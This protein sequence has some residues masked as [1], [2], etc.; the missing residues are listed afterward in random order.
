M[1]NGKRCRESLPLEPTPA[2]IK[3]AEQF[4]AAILESI[5]RGN[6]DYAVTF[7]NSKHAEELTN[8]KGQAIS[9]KVYFTRW[10]ND[11]KDEVKSS[12]FAGYKKITN[13]LIEEFGDYTLIELTPVLVKPW[14]RG[15]NVSKK[16]FSNILSV[17]RS[18]LNEA[19]KNEII[20]E[21]PFL[22][23][24]YEKKESVKTEKIDPFTIEEQREILS[25]C[26]EEE[27][28]QIQTF[29]WTGMRTG[30]LIALNWQDV[31]FH[32]GVIYVNKNIT[33]DS[34]GKFETPKTKAGNRAIKMLKPAR[35]ALMSQ[36]KITGHKDAVFL[37]PF[38]GERWDGSESIR[39]AWA[40]I[41]KRT[42]VRYRYPY[43]TRHTYA[44]MM[45]SAGE[46]I[47]WVAKQMG[48]S[49]WTMVARVYAKWIPD[50]NPT[51]G[52]KA[53]AIFG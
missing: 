18:A 1:Y 4:R 29:L 6:F 51:A 30:E 35:D 52:D 14:L 32:K 45:L 16:R 36:K 8:I 31:D 44:S 24:R 53:V 19:Q 39:Y 7:P 23:F 37:S 21:N 43:Q 9:V 26:S 48:H 20:P 47:M 33:R 40:K 34:K 50:A 13:N 22:N 49:D 25:V 27:K 46:P 5:M 28:N 42:N 2:N 15:M 38:T 3:K 41:L 10:L 17:I 12:T 11:I